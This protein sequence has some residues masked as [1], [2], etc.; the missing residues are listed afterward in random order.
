MAR[1]LFVDDDELERVYAQEILE[2]R[3][4]DVAFATNGAEALEIYR[5]IDARIDVV[6]TDLRMPRINGLRLIRELKE[7]DPK[8]EIIATSGVNAD[9]LL[10]AEDYGARTLLIKPWHPRDLLA[11]IDEA[12][13]HRSAEKKLGWDG[14]WD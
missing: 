7:W 11:A 4:H 12:V 1:I 6:I 2:P 3:G 14:S 5:A 8:A 9:Q 13:R 10:L